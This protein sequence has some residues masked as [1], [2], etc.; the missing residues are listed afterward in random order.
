MSALK[1]R[2]ASFIMKCLRGRAQHHVSFV[3]PYIEGNSI[4]DIGAAEGWTGEMI[5]QNAPQPDVHL[6]DIADFNQT[7]LPLTLYDGHTFPF[8]DNCFDTSLLLLILHHCDDPMR[9]LREAMRVTRHR[10]IITESVYHYQ[11]GRAALFVADNLVNALRTN[12]SMAWGL[13]FRT[14]AQWEACFSRMALSLHH[15]E[16][17]SKGFHKHI[18][19]VL[20]LEQEATNQ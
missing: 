16:W 11:A 7:D 5:K 19:F 13:K 6:L 20:N 10:L 3:R 18:L 2:P 14:A 1:Q 9:V 15:K 4:L 12:A 8:A 17:I